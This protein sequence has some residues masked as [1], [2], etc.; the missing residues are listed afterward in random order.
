[1][2][3]RVYK[4]DYKPYTGR[5]LSISHR[6]WILYIE[7]LK[8]ILF[9]FGGKFFKF[10]LYSSLAIPAISAISQLFFTYIR[11]NFTQKV[12]ISFENVASSASF[13]LYFMV[14]IAASFLM[15]TLMTSDYPIFM[16]YRNM[17][18]GMWL[19]LYLVAF[20]LLFVPMMLAFLTL[21]LGTTAMFPLQ[22]HF[23]QEFFNFLENVIKWTIVVLISDNIIITFSLLLKKSTFGSLAS[24]TYPLILGIV[25]SI[26][27]EI[28]AIP[29]QQLQTLNIAEMLFT[30]GDANMS[31]LLINLM[32]YTII[33]LMVFLYRRK[34]TW[35]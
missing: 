22:V 4:I 2:V 32:L 13:P 26:I 20:T 23:S 8:H 5:R 6:T 24:A 33:L 31:Y 34:Y 30:P 7:Y 11:Y 12:E 9:K 1:M 18:R 10:A 3:S 19:S 15:S 35:R 28:S 27:S 21:L 25:I 16:K 29:Y 17:E 14:A